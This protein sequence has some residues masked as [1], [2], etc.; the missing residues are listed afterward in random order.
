MSAAVAFICGT[1]LMACGHE[2]LGLIVALLG[3]VTEVNRQ[4]K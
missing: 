4:T 2:W 3:A 1:Y